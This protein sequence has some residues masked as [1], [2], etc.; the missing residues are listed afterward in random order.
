[1][2]ERLERQESRARDTMVLVEASLRLK[3]EHADAAKRVDQFIKEG[4]AVLKFA[5]G[6]TED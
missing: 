1:M 6:V 4:D 5:A 2:I 3:E